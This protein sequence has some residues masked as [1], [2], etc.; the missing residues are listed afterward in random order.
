MAGNFIKEVLYGKVS[1]KE[2]VGSRPVE[3]ERERESR[4]RVRGARKEGGREEMQKW[5][6]K[7]EF[8]E[9]QCQCLCLAWRL[10]LETPMANK[11]VI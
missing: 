9:R 10:P 1:R 6:S 4:D 2:E 3:E 8:L 7:S 11:L 5:R